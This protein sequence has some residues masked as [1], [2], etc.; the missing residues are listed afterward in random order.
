MFFVKSRSTH[1][2]LHDARVSCVGVCVRVCERESVCVC[3]HT[4]TN[5]HIRKKKF[6][7]ISPNNKNCRQIKNTL[8]TLKLQAREI[9]PNR[10]RGNSFCTTYCIMPIFR[11]FG[12]FLKFLGR[13]RELRLAIVLCSVV[14]LWRE[15]ASGLKPIAATRPG[16]V[17]SKIQI[18]VTP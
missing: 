15:A 17:V 8:F 11:I 7:E 6:L 4:K 5:T 12:L 3:T 1:L 16:A 13:K 10:R 14:S 9:S 18:D 2:L